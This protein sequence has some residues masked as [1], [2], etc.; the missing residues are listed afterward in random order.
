VT[1]EEF[2]GYVVGVE[3]FYAVGLFVMGEQHILNWNLVDWIERDVGEIK[4]LLHK[5]ALQM[6]PLKYQDDVGFRHSPPLT[7]EFNP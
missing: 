1:G 6:F 3:V 2:K 5:P 7:G 4:E